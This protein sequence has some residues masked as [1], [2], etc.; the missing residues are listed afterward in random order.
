MRQMQGQAFQG[1][2]VPG[3]FHDAIRHYQAGRPAEAERG[4]HA[5]LALQ[6]RH[7]DSLHL[8]G[9]IACQNGR[10][11]TAVEFIGRAIRVVSD[12]P[13]YHFSMGNAL[14]AQGKVSDAAARYRQVLRLNPNFAEAHNNL[15]VLLAGQNK[16]EDAAGHYR[17]ALLLKPDYAEGWNKRATIYFLQR[18]YGKSISDL[19]VVQRLQP[20]HVSALIGLATM[21]RELGDDKHAVVVLKQARAVSP[22]N[23]MVAKELKDLQSRAD[24]QDL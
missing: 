8:I 13:S 2:I 11:E 3:M 16:Y 14:A 5:V 1:Q 19:E 23:E 21:M 9:L 7:A 10:F 12:N 6:P 17:H 15:G 20:R 22:A 18:D 4:F 24:G